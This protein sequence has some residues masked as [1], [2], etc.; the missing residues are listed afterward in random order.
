VGVVGEESSSPQR[1]HFLRVTKEGFYDQVLLGSR[2]DPIHVRE[3]GLRRN[4][5]IAVDYKDLRSPEKRV[6]YH[7]SAQVEPKA[8]MTIAEKVADAIVKGQEGDGPNFDGYV[9]LHGLDT[10]AYSASGVAYLLGR[11]IDVPVIFTGSQRPLNYFRSDAVQ[12]I[13]AAITLAAGN[14]VHDQAS[15]VVREVSVYSCDRLFRGTR[16]SMRSA[17]SYLTFD[18]PNYPHLGYVGENIVIHGPLLKARGSRPYVPDIPKN[19]SARVAVLDVFPGIDPRVFA[20]LCFN[21]DDRVIDGLLLRAYGM[22][23]APTSLPVLTAIRH[24]VAEDVVVMLVTQAWSGSISYGLDPVALRLAECGVISGGDMTIEAAY[25]KL[26]YILSTE[27]NHQ[28]RIQRL[29]CD[30]C[31]EQSE[32]IHIYDYG[33]HKL[34]DN[35]SDLGYSKHLAPISVPPKNQLPPGQSPVYVQLRILDVIPPESRQRSY[36]AKLRISVEDSIGMESGMRTLVP[37]TESLS[38]FKSSGG[39]VDSLN[40]AFDITADAFDFFGGVEPKLHIESSTA[41]GW[42]ALSVHVFTEANRTRGNSFGNVMP[43]GAHR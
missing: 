43:D 23:T 16:V 30:L 26:I 1:R 8:W 19:L 40:V 5:R 12:N 3:G 22:G 36:S 32:S 21:G 28:K 37:E 24:L 17:S 38:W 25:A 27:R 14:T 6:E 7:D 42:K 20:A 13:R 2:R 4:A 11:Q 9:V 39:V 41:L 33:G 18:S 15:T 34:D 10:L 35:E 31:G 29:V